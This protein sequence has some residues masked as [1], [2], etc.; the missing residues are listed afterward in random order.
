MQNLSEPFPTE[1]NNRQQLRKALGVFL[2]SLLVLLVTFFLSVKIGAFH[3]SISTLFKTLFQYSGSKEQVLVATA[4]IPRAVVTVI[5]GANL[6]IA[7]A[8]M[9]A[10]TRNPLASPSIF[11]VNAGASVAIVFA[12]V[13]LSINNSLLLVFIAFLGGLLAVSIVYGM[14]ASFKGGNIEVKMAFTGIVIQAFLSSITQGLL[15]FNEDK[16]ESVLFWLAGSVTGMAWK[17]VW[18]LLPFSLLAMLISVSLGRF[19]SLISLGDEVAQGLGLRVA[20]LR[21]F[22]IVL[23]VILSGVAVSVAGPIGFVGLIVP[24]M[25]R[26]LVGRDYRWVI[27]ISAVF[28]SALLTLADV[29][30]RF[31]SFPY[32]TPV[33]VVT[34]L[35]GT[36]YFIYLARTKK[37]D[38]YEG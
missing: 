38:L 30:S 29:C 16:T 19:I 8:L 3:I 15:L 12:I 1:Q 32:E 18:I 14:S 13:V 2:I 33:G 11:G 10:I 17:H 22:V 25:V 5:I 31:I 4:R 37:G 9:Q 20:L 26:Y 24:H 28:G 34:A 35:I 23:V 21:R 7:G 27:P 6:G 36:P